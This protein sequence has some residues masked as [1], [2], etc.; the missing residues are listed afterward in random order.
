MQRY[1]QYWK[2]IGIT[3]C[4]SKLSFRI[5]NERT[6]GQNIPCILPDIVPLGADALL[7]IA[8]SGKIKKKQGKG[9]ADHILTLVDY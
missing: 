7:T 2:E 6:D 1:E 4:K 9:T 5:T 8:E 3:N